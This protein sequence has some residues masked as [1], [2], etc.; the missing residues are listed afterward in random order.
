MDRVI[1][2]LQAHPRGHALR[3]ARCAGVSPARLHVYLAQLEAQDAISSDWAE[4]P[5]PRRRR[6]WLSGNAS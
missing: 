6:Y 5:Y 3:L 2:A 1:L 4:G